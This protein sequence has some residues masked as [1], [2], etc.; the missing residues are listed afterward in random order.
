MRLEAELN[1]RFITHAELRYNMKQMSRIIRYDARSRDL[2]D[3]ETQAVLDRI[4]A[5]YSIIEIENPEDSSRSSRGQW[6]VQV[7][8]KG[9][10]EN[11]EGFFGVTS[12]EAAS[13][14]AKALKLEA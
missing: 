3:V 11:P 4:Q 8:R 12:L 1:F 7:Y 2:F 6:F 13:R 14:L 5:H 10:E 9:I